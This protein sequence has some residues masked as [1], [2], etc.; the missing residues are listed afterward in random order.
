[1]AGKSTKS[2][3]GRKTAVKKAAG[4]VKTAGPAKAADRKKSGK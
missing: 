3:G 1:M 2:A 4:T